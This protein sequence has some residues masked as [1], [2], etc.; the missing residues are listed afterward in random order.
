MHIEGKQM[1]HHPH[2]LKLGIS[3]TALLAAS[4]AC[5]GAMAQDVAAADG[6][7]EQV[8]VTGTSIRGVAAPVGTNLISLSSAD[9]QAS[10]ATTVEQMLAN[11]PVISNFGNAGEG[12]ERGLYYQPSIHNL[13]GAGS[14]ATLILIDGH[15]PPTG[16]TTH[17]TADPNIIPTN[18]LE[19][20][21]VIAN[22][23]SSIYGSNAVAGVINFITRSQYDGIQL[24]AESDFLHGATNLSGGVLAGKNWTGGNVIFA[25]Q[26]LDQ[27]KL[28]ASDRSFSANTDQTARAISAGLPVGDAGSAKTNFNSFTGAGPGCSQPL[29]RI[30]GTGSYYNLVTGQQYGTSASDAPCNLADEDT[31]IEHEERNNV[32]I[33]LSQDIGR[34]LTVGAQLLYAS[35]RDDGLAGAGTISNVTVFGSGA[36]AN[37][38]FKLPP[39]YT[40]TATKE[41]VY[42]NL[43]PI[44]GGPQ[45]YDTDG[46][47][48]MFGEF[49]AEYHLP[50]DFVIDAL[51]VA[52]RDDSYTKVLGGS[53]NAS[54]AY[55][56]LNGTTNSGGNPDTPAIANTTIVPLNLPLTASNALD[57]W[58][59]GSANQTAGSVIQSIQDGKSLLENISSFTQFRLST[60]GT[61]LHLPGG[62]LKV[63]A[64]VE[65]VKD[66]L[67]ESSILSN[68]T[69]PATAGSQYALYN[70][71]RTIKS[72]FGELNIPVVGGDMAVPFVQRFDVNASGRYDD[73]SDVGVTT[74]YKLAFDWVPFDGVKLRGNMS[75]SFVAPG[76]D[77][78]GNQYHAFSGTNFGATTAMDGLAIP[79]AAFPELTQFAPSQFNNGQPC[80]LASVTCVLA[81]TVQGVNIHNGA[82]HAHPALGRGWE[83][84]ADLAPDFLPGFQAQV[85][86]W[87][88]EYLGAFTTPSVANFLNT[89]ALYSQVHFYPGAGASPDMVY[90]AATGLQQSSALPPV[91]SA[92]LYTSV[93]NYL[94]LYIAGID[95]NVNYAF[96]TDWGSFHVGDT[97]TELTKY[98]EGLTATGTVFSVLNTTGANNSFPSPS[99]QMRANFGWTGDN[100]AA[101]LFINYVGPYRNWSGTSVIPLAKDAVGN[102]VGGGDPVKANVTFD[103]HLSYQLP[104]SAWGSDRVSLTVINLAD[105]DPPFYLGATGYDSW[106]ASPLGRVIK[107]GFTA[108][109]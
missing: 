10:G 23:D 25:Y 42:A 72:F 61:L 38:F 82:A 106:L 83:V 21:Q 32:M 50:G 62:A 58:N 84:G 79:V 93:G 51:A 53:A 28:L 49:D 13:G 63:A 11:T 76:L 20:V 8:T 67:Q 48:T 99:T 98:N 92:I 59:T 70:F 37:P 17:S 65:A 109:F 75:T 19:S 43:D 54:A 24:N 35:R 6:Q 90:A 73:Y 56:A 86:Y 16:G 34:N 7:V 3:L 26:Y 33:K 55:L 4:G 71:E 103:L 22:G 15:L 108:A 27:G 31:L 87:D 30:D 36:Q 80:T 9:L 78:I 95:A 52:G 5:G 88:T 29:A 60:N 41:T 94:Y 101:D 2:G 68:N 104:E 18:M 64:G 12:Q 44:L 46:A 47:D 107:I 39:G 96:D 85:T 91:I 81:P 40:G 57:I 89:P 102:P 14:N 45:D 66:T 77:Q 69:G 74:N 105:T 1:R 97:V 100:L